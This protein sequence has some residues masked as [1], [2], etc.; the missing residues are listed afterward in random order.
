MLDEIGVYSTDITVN[1]HNF[2]K[3]MKQVAVVKQLKW[4]HFQVTTLRCR[5]VGYYVLDEDSKDGLLFSIL[6]V[7]VCNNVNLLK[8][9][10]KILKVSIPRSISHPKIDAELAQ[11][12]LQFMSRKYRNVE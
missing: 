5:T 11:L 1:D 9:L 7:F 6:A 4:S 3:L 8:H 2:S 12:K 10:I